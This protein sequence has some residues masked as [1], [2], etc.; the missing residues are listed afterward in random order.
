MSANPLA[1]TLPAQTSRRV[2]GPRI[3]LAS[4]VVAA[5]LANVV[6][7]TITDQLFHELGVY[8]PWGQPMPDVG[9][10]ALALAYRTLFAVLGGY[11]A[12]ALAA[13]RAT[14]DTQSLPMR[15]ALYF[16]IVGLVLSAVGAAVTI[17]LDLGPDW[18]PLLLVVIALPAAW[19]GGTL[20]QR[21]RA[22]R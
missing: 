11:L 1:T 17:R 19:L 9:D 13:R 2:A 14:P 7:T 22:A 8:P 6:I 3:R 20:H 4:A 12:A 18:Y 21:R 10:N 15:A 16:G 5:L